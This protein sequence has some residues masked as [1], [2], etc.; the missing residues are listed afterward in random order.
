MK[1]E[2]RWLDGA[3][4][5]VKKLPLTEVLLTQ[6]EKRRAEHLVWTGAL[7]VGDVKVLNREIVVFRQPNNA[8]GNFEF[9]AF[10]T[11][12]KKARRK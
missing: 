11:L 9:L 3:V 7:R 5:V 12:P 6:K 10:R 2:Y 1:T 8:L 4:Y